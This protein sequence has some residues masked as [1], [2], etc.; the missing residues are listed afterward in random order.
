M[1]D[2]GLDGLPNIAIVINKQAPIWEGPSFVVIMTVFR[3][4]DLYKKLS[5]AI[6]RA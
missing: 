2:T 6:F 4:I 5:T 1:G 3:S